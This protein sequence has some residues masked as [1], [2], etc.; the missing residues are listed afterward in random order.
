VADVGHDLLMRSQQ[1]NN[2]YDSRQTSVAAG[3][4]FTFGTMVCSPNACG[5][6]KMVEIQ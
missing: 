3:G 1:N 4:S 5:R 2:D 6:L